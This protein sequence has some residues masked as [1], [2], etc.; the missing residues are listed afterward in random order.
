MCIGTV[1]RYALFFFRFCYHFY[2]WSDDNKSVR[3]WGD[4]LVNFSGRGPTIDCIVKPDIIAPGAH[5][6][7]C[8][9]PTPYHDPANK[10]NLFV[11]TEMR[12]DSKNTDMLSG[13]TQLSGTS[14]STPI[15]TGAIA[16][17]LQKYPSLQPD[18]IKHLLKHS[19]NTLNYPQN[20][21]GW[22][23]LDVEKLISKEERHVRV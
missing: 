15:V 18:D 14:M 21:Q 7:S 6:T 16:L 11:P 19:T 10:E 12:P 17:L 3:I 9:T 23:L 22:G 4:T 8:L 1:Q 13:Y 2:V 20:Q 5:I